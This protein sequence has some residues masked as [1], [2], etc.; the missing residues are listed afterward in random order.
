MGVEGRDLE[1]SA[2]SLAR[3]R[4]LVERQ[5]SVMRMAVA[6][7]S[8]PV[9]LHCLLDWRVRVGNRTRKINQV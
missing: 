7:V 8:A 2:R 3:T 4:G 9:R 1:I 5:K 6:V